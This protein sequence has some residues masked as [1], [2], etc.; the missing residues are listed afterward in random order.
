MKVE[1]LVRANVLSAMDSY[2]KLRGLD[3]IA[4]L[5][6]VGLRLDEIKEPDT[7]V[8]LNR[9]G[10]LFDTISQRLGDPAFGLH[11]AEHFPEGATGLLGN[12]VL[13]AAT[14]RA[15]LKAAAEFLSVQTMP[16]DSHFVE[17]GGL[18]HLHWKFSA[19]FRAPR[20]QFTGFTAATFLR[21]LRLAAGPGWE[22][23]AA[24]FD[25]G[26]PEAVRGYRDLFGD[27]IKFDQS[28]NGMIIDATTL[29]LAVPP[30]PL[31]V[32]ANLQELG[33]RRLTELRQSQSNPTSW[34]HMTVP[35]QV[36]QEIERRLDGASGLSFDQPTIA[37]VLGMPARELQRELSQFGTS[38]DRILLS[39]REARADRYLRDTDLTLSQ[40]SVKLGFAEAST[41]SRWAVRAFQQSP[42]SRRESLRSAPT[43]PARTTEPGAEVGDDS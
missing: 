3:F 5:N 8:S 24:R 21:R 4:L 43:A 27:R 42:S 41:F 14:V 22:P 19:E 40:I 30:R 9:V 18:G 28:D 10:Q 1:P 15:S 32:F 29:A 34:H 36:Q 7:L 23:L 25:H 38:Y 13:S 6:E 20:I 39:I 12:L 31:P 37:E 16:V 17:H 35:Q 33:T 26:I 11:Y 2:V